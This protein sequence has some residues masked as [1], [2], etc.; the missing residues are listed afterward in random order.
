MPGFRSCVPRAMSSAVRASNSA[1]WMYQVAVGWLALQLTDI[2]FTNPD[3]AAELRVSIFHV[4]V[5]RQ[6]HLDRAMQAA[7]P[8]KGLYDG[9]DGVQLAPEGTTYADSAAFYATWGANPPRAARDAQARYLAE[10]RE[11]SAEASGVW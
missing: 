3:H 10:I 7:R 2:L 9:V 11:A 8:L 1:F 4:L 6:K 5:R